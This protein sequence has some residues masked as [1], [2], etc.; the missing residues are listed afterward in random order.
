MAKFY[1]LYGAKKSKFIIRLFFYLSLTLVFNVQVFAQKG[2]DGAVPASG[3]VNTTITT[4]SA[5]ATAGS[6]TISVASTAGFA[7]GD[8][9]MIIQ[10]QGATINTTATDS[11]WGAITAYNNAGNYEV[12]EVG[13][14]VGGNIGFKCGYTLKNNYSMTGKTQIIRIPRYT[15]GTI[16]GTL[17]APAWN[18]T[19]G[20]VLA[21]EVSGDLTITGK[22]DAVGKGFRG[23]AVDPTGFS[24]IATNTYFDMERY[25][26]EKGEGI[27]GGQAEYDLI[28]PKH[29]LE[30][31]SR[32]F[33]RGAPANGGGGG[34]NHNGG[35]GGGANAGALGNYTG[36]GTPDISNPQFAQAWNLEY[37]GFASSTSSGGGRGGYG[38]SLSVQ[39]PFTTGPGNNAWSGAKRPNVGG[40][41]GR[42]LDYG[43]GKIFLGGGGGAGDQN[44]GMGGNGGNGGG[45][46]WASV[47]GNITGSGQIDANGADGQDSGPQDASGGAGGGGVAIINAGGTINGVAITADG[48]SGGTQIPINNSPPDAAEAEGPGAG[49]GGGYV[50]ISGGTATANG[51]VSGTTKRWFLNDHSTEVLP[52]WQKGYKYYN[53]PMNGATRGGAGVVA[54]LT[55][56][57]SGTVTVDSG[58]VCKGGK[59]TLTASANVDWYDAPV[60]G[61]LLLSASKTFIT[62]A[63]MVTDTFYISTNCPELCKRIP[64]IVKVNPI[65]N[66]IVTDPS[67]VCSPGTVNITSAFTDANSTTGTVTYWSDAATTTSSITAASAALI[68]TSGKYYI[69]KVAGGCTDTSVV[70]VVINPTP[71]VVVTDPLPVCSPGTVSITGSWIDN[72]GSTS[73]SGTVSY[74]SDATTSSTQL[75]GAEA[76]AIGTGKYYIKKAVGNCTDTSVVNVTIHP[77]PDLSAINPAA[78]YYPNTVDITGSWSDANTLTSG[79]GVTYWKDAAAT[80]QLPNPDKVDASG[81]YYIKK[82]TPQGCTDIVPVDV[83]INTS[84][85]DLVAVDTSGCAPLTVDITKRWKDLN[86]TTVVSVEYFTDKLL[87]SVLATPTN[88]TTSGTYYVKKTTSGGI[89][90]TVSIAVSVHPV[91]DIRGVD[92]APVCSPA[93]VDITPTP[94]VW[95]DFNTL[96]DGQGDITYWRDAVMTIPMT[97]TA[98]SSISTSG[99]YYIKKTTSQGCIDTTIVKVQVNPPVTVTATPATICK[100]DSTTLSAT[101]GVS[102]LWSPST[103]LSGTTGSSVKASPADNATYTVRGTDSNGCFKDTTVNINVNP[104]P[105]VIATGSTICAG[106]TATLSASGATTYTWNPSGETTANIAVKPTVTTVY[107]ATG[108]DGNGCIGIDT[109][110]VVVNPLPVLVVTP[111]SGICAGGSVAL[112]ASGANDYSWAPST[113]LVPSS[114]P[115]VTASPGSTTTYTVIG[116]SLG[117]ANTAS[118]IV[119]VNAQPTVDVS[120]DVSICKGDSATLIGSLASSYTWSPSLGL[121][122]AQGAVVKVSPPVGTTTYTVTGTTSGCSGTASK[123][124]VV[125]VNDLPIV[126]AS[127]DTGICKGASAGL[128]ATTGLISYIWTPSGTITGGSGTSQI[129]VTPLLSTMYVVTATDANSCKNKDSVVVTVHALPSLLTSDASICEGS[130]TTLQVTGAFSYDWSPATGLSSTAGS[131]VTASPASTTTYTIIGTDANGCKDTTTSL[132]TIKPIP[133]VT[134]NSPSVCIGEQATLSPRG[135]KSYSWL[136]SLAATGTTSDS[137]ILVN[138]TSTV[139]YIIQGTTNGCS[140]TAHARVTVYQLPV[141]TA[142]ND[143]TICAGSVAPLYAGGALSYVWSPSGSL[144]TPDGSLVQATPVS[145]TQYMVTGTDVNG[146]KSSEP[147]Q[148]TVNPIPVITVSRD[149]AICEGSSVTLQASGAVTNWTWTGLVPEETGSSITVSPTTQNSYTVTGKD[150]IGCQSS[151]SVTVTIFP[152]LNPVA[153]PAVSICAGE[154]VQLTVLAQGATFF[155]WSTGEQASSIQVHPGKTTAYYVTVSNGGCTATDTVEIKVKDETPAQVYIPNAFTPNEDKLN[156]VFKVEPDEHLVMSFEGMIFNRWG[157]LYYQWENIDEGWDG[158]YQGKLVQEDVYIYKINV[159]NECS[160]ALDQRIGTVTVIK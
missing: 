19:T 1:N 114:G 158:K 109:A 41:G 11:T 124:V 56:G 138:T 146:C 45:I 35:G 51:G 107:T 16:S 55:P 24:E 90:D 9:F 102:Y 113:G 31:S 87:S 7:V 112:N 148:V 85:P 98:A 153:G 6:L 38:F 4:L 137:T 123:D 125:T 126:I 43:G 15:T 21:I 61:N 103:G 155:S 99:N 13:S 44:N 68:N 27:A 50:A 77:T 127:Q 49:G 116:T 64:A 10:M 33:G 144:N 60:G 95:K 134:V 115:A 145:L 80:V 151:K 76:A 152:P 74:W 131:A 147:V 57:S 142:S 136:S 154:T 23:G 110:E 78:V 117:C 17:S 40:K 69:K 121:S 132:L 37:N 120:P 18:G 156:D 52:D 36:N 66:I 8:L 72:N 63:M 54:S 108:T 88:V 129:T 105:V 59:D 20:G 58:L 92:P 70:N 149:T 26:A 159:K 135:A 5:N 97:A 62:P 150:N 53:F 86:N 29:P 82:T 79:I 118:V 67:P 28:I 160:K 42:P 65:P 22:M 73:G 139:T 2:K 130:D 91:P 89:S 143:T 3:I 100:G 111:A 32:R 157:E 25:G 12:A 14:V 96:T 141:I 83:E 71:S 84:I 81:R 119:T 133:V 47:C 106:S 39:D 140:D 30:N 104:L 46:I 128:R 122:S 94:M 75:T 101:G 48:G 93:T 34:N